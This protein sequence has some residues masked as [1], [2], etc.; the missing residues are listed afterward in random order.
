MAKPCGEW[1]YFTL[2]ENLASLSK[3]FSDTKLADLAKDIP[4]DK[5]TLKELD[6]P[7]LLR[8]DESSR[9]NGNMNSL[10]ESNQA[11][12]SWE[13]RFPRLNGNMNSLDESNSSNETEEAE[14]KPPIQNK[15]D[16]IRRENEVE[17]ELEEKYPQSEGYT[18]EK[19]IYLRDKDG[20]IIKDTETGEARRIDFAVTKDGKVVETIEV[21]S[22]TA[23]KDAQIAKE[24]RIRE[25]GGNYIKD[26]NGNIIEI[27]ENVKTKVERR[28]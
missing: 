11:R 3:G 1:R 17:T 6:K 8:N 14:K 2:I 9:L 5:L 18:I 24:E 28:D 12:L 16:G 10:D 13:E 23:S 20:N 22:N 21:T 25:N 15:V 4:K 19:E 27:P 7:L 26:S